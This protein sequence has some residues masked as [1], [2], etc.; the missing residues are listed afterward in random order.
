MYEERGGPDRSEEKGGDSF[1]LSRQLGP[2]TK[3]AETVACRHP[4]FIDIDHVAG[5]APLRTRIMWMLQGTPERVPAPQ[6]PR[7][8]EAD[9][10]KLAPRRLSRTG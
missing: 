4:R 10:L 3:L 9:S 6:H 8:A 2:S 7:P 5:L 1:G